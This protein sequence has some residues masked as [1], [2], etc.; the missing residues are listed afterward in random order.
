MGDVLWILVIILVGVAEQVMV[1][2]R[3]W[4]AAGGRSGACWEC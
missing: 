3:S 2:K 1:E 4:C